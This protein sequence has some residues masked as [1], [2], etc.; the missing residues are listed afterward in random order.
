M[1]VIGDH[2]P[3]EQISQLIG[4][5]SAR[6]IIMQK[7]KSSFTYWYPNLDALRF[8][9]QLREEITS[10]ARRLNSSGA[11][12]AK[13]NNSRCNEAYW[14]RES[15]GGFRLK[16]G[17]EPSKAIQDIYENG[18]LYAFECGTAI[19]IVWYKAV[20]ESISPDA[21]DVYFTNLFLWDGEHDPNLVLKKLEQH[22]DACP[23]DVQYFENPDVDP[24]KPEWQ[25]ENVV[26]LQ[27]NLYY[28]HGIGIATSERII[29]ALNKRR[30]PNSS[31]SAYLTKYVL[32]P[33]FEFLRQFQAKPVTARI[34]GQMLQVW[35]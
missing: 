4:S 15:N 13:F 7:E 33:D 21:F 25:G 6:A 2:T 3:S 27:T 30:K 12:F 19:V 22:E 5:E 35:A 17:V 29:A 23:G 32:H 24:D 31:I 26:L 16:Q 11:K 9:L 18:P 20:I 14:N 34:G 28:G 10:A 8:E 1:I